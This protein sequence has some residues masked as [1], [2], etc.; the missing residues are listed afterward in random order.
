MRTL[1]GAT[2]TELAAAVTRPGYL[3]EIAFSTT[4]RLSSRSTVDWSG[5]TWAAADFSVSGLAADSASTAT[6][7]TVS[8]GNAD[9]SMSAYILGDGVAG[10]AINIW[11]FYGD[12][13]PIG[14]PV[15]LF[16]GYG[17]DATIDDRGRAS[18][19]LQQAGGRSLFCPRT[20]ITPESGFNWLPPQGQ[21]ITWNGETVVLTPD[22]I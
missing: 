17:D 16:S 19:S 10:R 6:D 7:G 13:A 12:A 14:D 3:I 11:K 9:L 8:F 5:Q 2:S 20:Y 22:G 4:V 1:A 15:L 18:V 21:K